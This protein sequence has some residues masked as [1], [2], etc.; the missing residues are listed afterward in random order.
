MAHTPGPWKTNSYGD[1]IFCFI[2]SRQEWIAYMNDADFRYQS[3]SEEEAEEEQRANARLIAA[4][5]ELLEVAREAKGKWFSS[6]AGRDPELHKRL[7]EAI[8]KAEGG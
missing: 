1:T 7:S 6:P 4:A 8:A 5:P 2:D 3:L